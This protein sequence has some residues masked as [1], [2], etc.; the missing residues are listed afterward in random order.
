[1]VW[2]L[3]M[4]MKHN[5]YNGTVGFNQNLLHQQLYQKKSFMKKLHQYDGLTDR[6]VKNLNFLVNASDEVL[7]DW[8][9]H[10]DADDIDYAQE[11]LEMLKH[12][13]LDIA[14]EHSDLSET[15]QILARY[16]VSWPIFQAFGRFSRS[17]YAQ[18][19]TH[20]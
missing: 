5:F 3:I 10:V 2:L 12:R 11:L 1:M 6:D 14:A 18:I 4:Y 16:K 15:K 8:M 13:I 17:P 20:P 9:N 19:S 7:R